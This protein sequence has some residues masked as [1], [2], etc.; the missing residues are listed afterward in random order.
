MCDDES[1][2]MAGICCKIG[3]VNS[4][5]NCVDICPIGQVFNDD[6][7]C[8]DC[9]SGEVSNAARDQCINNCT[10]EGQ[11]LSSQLNGCY[12]KCIDGNEF[13][14]ADGTLCVKNCSIAGE[15]ADINGD[16]RCD[17]NCKN[18]VGQV[19]SLVGDV[20]IKNC[21]IVQLIVN[22]QNDNCLISCNDEDE[23]ENELG[24]RCLKASL[25]RY[26]YLYV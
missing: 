14:N 10:E 16:N 17:A 5:N 24:D 8:I 21:A 4:N 6:R 15:T 3:Q 19:L 25:F 23:I 7:V 2:I 12:E 1:E 13:S 11:I 18:Q 26:C 22:S 9:P 20:C